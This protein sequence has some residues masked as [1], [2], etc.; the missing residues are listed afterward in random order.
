MHDEEVRTKPLVG[1]LQSRAEHVDLGLL[2]PATFIPKSE[3]DVA[4]FEF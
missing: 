4:G 3:A 1:I 2:E